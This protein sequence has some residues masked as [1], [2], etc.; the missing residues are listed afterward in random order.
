MMGK[1]IYICNNHVPKKGLLCADI[2]GN[3]WCTSFQYAI[4]YMTYTSCL[5]NYFIYYF[6]VFHQIRISLVSANDA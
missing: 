1:D 5:K 4:Q 2:N 6:F 3:M